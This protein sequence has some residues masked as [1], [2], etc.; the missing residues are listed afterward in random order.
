MDHQSASAESKDRENKAQ[1]LKTN[2]VVVLV[3]PKRGKDHVQ[4]VWRRANQMAA[5][6]NSNRV[7]SAATAGNHHDLDDDK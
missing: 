3:A 6:K 7:R 5:T 4:K 2:K 1:D